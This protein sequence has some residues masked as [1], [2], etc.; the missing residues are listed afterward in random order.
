[1]AISASASTGRARAGSQ[2]ISEI[3]ERSASLVAA[4]FEASR[5]SA[6]AERLFDELSRMSPGE[7]EC[8]GMSRC[9]VA[10]KVFDDCYG[11]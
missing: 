10:R 3:F 8:L 4:Y 7:L 9:D 5:A 2:A 6:R 11:K 1:M